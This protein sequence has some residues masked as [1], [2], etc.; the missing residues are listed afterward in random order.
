MLMELIELTVILNLSWAPN[1]AANQ[2]GKSTCFK[3]CQVQETFPQTDK[4]FFAEFSVLLLFLPSPTP[5]MTIRI[6]GN[7]CNT[8]RT[9]FRDLQTSQEIPV[10]ISH[11]ILFPWLSFPSSTNWMKWSLCSARAQ[12]VILVLLSLSITLALWKEDYWLNAGIRQNLCVLSDELEHCHVMID[13]L[14]SSVSLLFSEIDQTFPSYKQ[15][16]L[17]CTQCVWRGNIF[18]NAKRFLCKIWKYKNIIFTTVFLKT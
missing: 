11:A 14:R 7:V 12:W 13:L 6:K 8:W 16:S 5:W 18:F 9:W 10:T 3:A 1:L 17:C 2:N 15:N 4:H